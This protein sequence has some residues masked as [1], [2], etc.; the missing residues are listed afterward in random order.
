MQSATVMIEA[1]YEPTSESLRQRPLPDWF[2]RAKFGLLIHWGPYSVP[3]WAERSGIVQELWSKKGPA[4]F[5]KHNPYAEW[6][7]N[8]MEIPGSGTQRHHR[9]TYGPHVSYDEFIP[10]FNAEAAQADFSA[11]AELFAR[12][13]ARYVVLTTKHHDGFVLWPSHQPNPHKPHYRADRDIVGDVT[14]AVRARGLKMG[15]YYSGGYDKTFN[16]TVIRSLL[17]AVTAIPQSRQYADYCNAHVME[18]IERYRPSVLWNDIAYPA[19]AGLR[20]LFA[21]YYNSVPDGLVND[22]WTQFRMPK[23]LR[24]ALLVAA[25]RGVSLAW[26]LLPASWRRLQMQARSHHDFSTPEYEV[27]DS[28]REKKWEAVRGMGYSFGNNR[29]ERDEDMLS[30]D[31]LVRMLVD[32]VSKNGNLLL[33]IAPETGGAYPETQTRRLLAIGEWLAVNGEAIYDTTPWVQAEGRTADGVPVRYTHSDG[34]L[35]AVLLSAPSGTQLM[36]AGLT[37]AE[38]AEVRLLGRQQPLAWERQA[39]GLLITLPQPLAPSP[40][41]AFR[42]SP[43]PQG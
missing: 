35:Y 5:L 26:P 27:Y 39:G 36:I 9:E 37:A 18:L 1:K 11:W 43:P 42:I 15:L 3:A 40:A 4:Y 28:A 24:R 17:T 13:G 38:G 23:G 14:D 29:T 31:E 10:Q 8:T 22:R 21:F 33:G 7:L 12:A 25:I 32:V 34:A 30:S 6:Y 20:E 19:D 41:Y 2:D 16:T